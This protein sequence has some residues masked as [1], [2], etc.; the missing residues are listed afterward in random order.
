MEAKRA[1]LECGF[2]KLFT[3]NV[4]HVFEKIF[5]NCDYTSFKQCTEVSSS[6]SELL[7]SDSYKRLGKVTFHE[8]IVRDLNL[9]FRKGNEYD[10]RRTL[11][12]GM[13]DLDVLYGTN[14][15]PLINS[16][17]RGWKDVVKYLLEEGADVNKRLGQSGP[18]A[19]ALHEAA[20]KG[21]YEVAK[22]LIGRSDIGPPLNIN[23]SP[24]HAASNEGHTKVVKLLLD[25]GADV[26]TLGQGGRTALH[27]AAY[28]GH[29]DVAK[30]L[31]ARGANVNMQENMVNST[32]LHE[33]LLYNSCKFSWEGQLNLVKLLLDAGADVNART[34]F[35]RTPLYFALRDSNIET[36]DYLAEHGG[37]T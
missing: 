14:V 37:T 5:F 33:V 30:L 28:E 24:L 11:T 2:D 18:T 21:H 17:R 9:A 34:Y 6:W 32:P 35:G 26:N 1:R 10:A 27:E 3:K 7:T 4:P 20:W 16:A 23:F 25:A 13:V 31:I 29:Y 15:C 22:L 36:I 8:D 19:L 12:S